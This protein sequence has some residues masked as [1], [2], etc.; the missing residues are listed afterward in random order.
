M[1]ECKPTNALMGRS[2]NSYLIGE[3]VGYSV[4]FVSRAARVGSVAL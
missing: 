2:E 3:C 1:Y 4:K